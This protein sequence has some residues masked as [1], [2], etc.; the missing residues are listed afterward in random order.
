MSG[1]APRLIECRGQ[2]AGPR[3]CG[4]VGAARWRRAISN[5]QTDRQKWTDT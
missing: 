5:R 4:D 3:A 2:G 1:P